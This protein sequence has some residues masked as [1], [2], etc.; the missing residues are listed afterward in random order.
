MTT[1]TEFLGRGWGFPVRPEPGTRALAQAA[2]AEKVRQSIRLILETAPGERLMR[3]TFGC[4]LRDFLMQPN[5]TATR[6]LIGRRVT[7]ALEAFEPRIAL[8]EVRVE[9]GDDPALVLIEVVYTHVRDGSAGNLVFP[10]YL[11]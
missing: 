2:G 7:Q 1:T 4:G 8:S 9:P 5:T 10:F 3:P 11:L 6:A